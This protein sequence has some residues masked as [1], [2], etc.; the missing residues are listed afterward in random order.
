MLGGSIGAWI[1]SHY[2]ARV[3]ISRMLGFG[4]SCLGISGTVALV[5]SHCSIGGLRRGRG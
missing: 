3:G 1:N 2:V 5:G 4:A